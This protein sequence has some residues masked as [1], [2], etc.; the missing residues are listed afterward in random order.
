MVDGLEKKIGFRKN[1]LT[2]QGAP[3]GTGMPEELKEATV[4]YY[5]GKGISVEI[6][7]KYYGLG[8]SLTVE[9][10]KDYW[11]QMLAGHTA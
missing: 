7:K 9:P 1:G 6:L 4:G 5:Q 3:P 8:K 11:K 10:R 2:V